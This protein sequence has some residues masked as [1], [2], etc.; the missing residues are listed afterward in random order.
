M[1]YQNKNWLQQLQ[2]IQLLTSQITAARHLY[3]KGAGGCGGC[4]GGVVGV[5]L[6]WARVAFFD[7]TNNH[8]RPVL[9]A[10]QIK[11]WTGVHATSCTKCDTIYCLPKWCEI[12]KSSPRRGLS[13]LT[14]ASS[15][16][17]TH[18]QDCAFQHT[19]KQCFIIP[20]IPELQSIA[21]V[22]SGCPNCPSGN[23]VALRLSAR[24]TT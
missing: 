20:N 3:C 16:L 2:I 1:I 21:C 14:V 4:W 12:S 11:Q 17:V 6:W 22:A 8:N 9:K 7:P 5:G 23:R 19:I 24:Y 18:G 15:M 10:Q 13:T